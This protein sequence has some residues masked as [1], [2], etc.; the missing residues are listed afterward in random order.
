MRGQK[1]FYSD[2][3]ICVSPDK[4]TTCNIRKPGKRRQSVHVIETGFAFSGFQVLGF[5]SYERRWKVTL[6][7]PSPPRPDPAPLRPCSEGSSHICQFRTQEERQR[8]TFEI[9][10][11]R[12][13]LLCR[14]LQKDCWNLDFGVQYLRICS[15]NG[16][17][18]SM[19][20]QSVQYQ[21]QLLSLDLQ[22][23]K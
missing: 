18:T 9:V 12:T 13:V 16:P 7:P 6:I 21:A 8:Q 3:Q 19:S 23:T 2:V 5:S 20:I 4:H 17:P 11:I 22:A 15:V 1:I 14:N 10:R